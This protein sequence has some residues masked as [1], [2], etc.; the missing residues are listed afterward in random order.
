MLKRLFAIAITAAA[1]MTLAV[2]SAQS[3][4]LDSTSGLTLHNIV[5]EATTL[6]G[7]TGL[8]FTADPEV[9]KATA[10]KRKMLLAEMQARGE[11]PTGP[12]SFEG[13]R[14]NHLAIVD[15]VEFSNGTIEVEVAGSPAPGAQGGARGFVGVAFR[16][17]RRQRGVRLLLP[18]PH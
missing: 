16:V 6:D 17:K 1:F 12:G 10:V 8:M 5:A 3:L 14:T 18:A 4:S 11:R 9:V 2:A 13:L 15:G 7:M